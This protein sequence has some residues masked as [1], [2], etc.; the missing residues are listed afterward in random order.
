MQEMVFDAIE[1]ISGAS[2]YEVGYALGHGVRV[3]VDAVVGLFTIPSGAADDP[4][5]VG[6]SSITKGLSLN[7]DDQASGD[8]PIA[9]AA[10]AVAIAIGSDKLSEFISGVIEGYN[11]LER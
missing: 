2:V 9:V 4:A 1:A 8:N 7:E 6:A 10:L 3:A 11:G 5:S